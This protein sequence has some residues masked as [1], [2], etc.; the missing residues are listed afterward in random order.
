MVPFHGEFAHGQVVLQFLR[1]VEG[2]TVYPR[3]HGPFFITAPVTARDAV[4]FEAFLGDLASVFQVGPLAHV[5]KIATAVKRERIA[6]GGAR[7]DQ[8]TG[9]FRFVRFARFIQV[10]EGIVE[11]F[12]RTDERPPF[13]DDGLHA[14]FHFGEIGFS[15]GGGTE[16]KIV[17]KP[18]FNRGPESQFRFRPKLAYGR[19]KDMGQ[20]MS[21]PVYVC[22]F[23]IFY[24]VY[25]LIHGI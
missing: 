15:E 1:R 13:F 18:V 22:F 23:F 3:Q 17:I 25:R 4:Q 19:G 5:R 2:N 9:I 14:A 8:L 16:I 21:Q 12:F 24:G 20:G 11:R 7:V 10:Q 6:C